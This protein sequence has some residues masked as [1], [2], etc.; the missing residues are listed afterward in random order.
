MMK[1]PSPLGICCAFSPRRQV[2]PG[3][4]QCML[5]F[6][7]PFYGLGRKLSLS[8]CLILSGSLE[9]EEWSLVWKLAWDFSGLSEVE[10]NLHNVSRS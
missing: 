3:Y 10:I 1:R 6:L 8:W 4:D 5:L 2:V 9:R 7:Q